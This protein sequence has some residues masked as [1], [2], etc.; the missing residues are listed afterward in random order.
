MPR[1]PTLAQ[2]T[3]L[4]PADVESVRNA[5]AKI[6]D[7]HRYLQAWAHE[8]LN[9]DAHTFQRQVELYVGLELRLMAFSTHLRWATSLLTSVRIRLRNGDTVACFIDAALVKAQACS[10]MMSRGS[11]I[12]DEWHAALD[13]EELEVVDWHLWAAT[14]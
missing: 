10:S 7:I 13:P 11:Y 6:D 14:P 3:R 9:F 12:T 2:P 5:G 4:S 8:A 1:P